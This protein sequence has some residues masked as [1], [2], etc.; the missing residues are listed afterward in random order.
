MER[1]YFNNKIKHIF[2]TDLVSGSIFEEA[3]Q[4][5]QAAVELII[6]NIH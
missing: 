1:N 2:S 6:N 5:L 4:H 3:Y